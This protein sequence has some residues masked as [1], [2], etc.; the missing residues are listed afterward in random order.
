MN[1]INKLRLLYLLKIISER[2]DEERFL[3]TAGLAQILEEEYGIQSHR[4]TIVADIEVLREFGLDIQV[5]ASTQNR[6][7]LVSRDFDIAE[8][9]LLIDAVESSK[10]ITKKKSDELVGKLSGLLGKAQADRVKRNISV[11]K[12]IKH[13]NEKIY[14]IIDAINE[15]INEGKK[16]SFPYFKYDLNKR[17]KYKNKGNPFV[18]S[19]HRLVWN[20]D[21]YYMVGVFE[22]SGEV[23]IFRVDRIG[24]R[25]E[26]LEEA[27]IALPQGFRLEEHLNAT[28]RMFG[29]ETCKVKLECEAGTIDAILDH[30]GK[31]IEI[32]L[33]SEER[34]R[35]EPDI[36]V[37]SV[38]FSWVFGFGGMV[39]ILGPRQVKE[40]YA[41]MIRS[42]MESVEEEAG[43]EAEGIDPEG[44]EPAEERTV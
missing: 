30:F 4:Q 36:A 29:T 9:R 43:S 22:G 25:P 28:F 13:D 10:F 15:A 42:A 1:N 3:T 21:F 20:G 26:L 34:F 11:E 17:P 31:D 39:K 37:S 7:S 5:I 14:L 23:G 8:V 19:P 38:F 18:F 40:D 44:I 2:T 12:R 32:E 33:L 41:R 35:V 6:Y 27:A 16:I 24:K